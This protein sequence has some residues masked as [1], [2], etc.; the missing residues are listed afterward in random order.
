MTVHGVGDEYRGDDLV[1][2]GC[3]CYA[4]LKSCQR[5]ERHE[6]LLGT[7]YEWGNVPM[8]FWSL[9]DADAKDNQTNYSEQEAHV[10][11]P[12]PVLRLRP[13]TSLLGPH[14]HPEIT[15]SATKLFTNH[16][17]YDDTQKLQSNLLLVEAEFGDK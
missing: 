4:D 16:R 2:D 12:K 10:A 17:T 5:C 1:A 7:T 14:V 3:Y 11:Q 13:M 15:Q 8:S 6:T 9:L